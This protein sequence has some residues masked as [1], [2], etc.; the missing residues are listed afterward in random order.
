MFMYSE[1][2]NTRY[3]D[4][5]LRN[6]NLIMLFVQYIILV[7]VAGYLLLFRRIIK[8]ILCHNKYHI[9]VVVVSVS[10]NFKIVLQLLIA[11]KV[12]TYKIL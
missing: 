5:V 6:K 8:G 7:N 9:F 12:H 1:Q 4:T 2:S 3:I 10:I 11:T